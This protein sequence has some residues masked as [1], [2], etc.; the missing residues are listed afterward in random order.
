[1]EGYPVPEAEADIALESYLQSYSEKLLPVYEVEEAMSVLR[2]RIDADLFEKIIR[3]NTDYKTYVTSNRTPLGS[4]IGLRG[5]GSTVS[6]STYPSAAILSELHANA[7]AMPFD[8]RTVFSNQT[9]TLYLFCS[10]FLFVYCSCVSVYCITFLSDDSSFTDILLFAPLYLD[11]TAA[12]WAAAERYLYTP[13]IRTLAGLLRIVED[14][15]D[16]EKLFDNMSFT[17]VVTQLRKDYGSDFNKVLALCRSHI[18][19]EAKNILI[20]KIMGEVAQ[21]PIPTVQQ[22]PS[23]PMGVPLKNEINTRNLKLRLTALARLRQPVYSHVSFVANMVLMKQYTLKPEQRRQRMHETIMAA[24]TTGEPVGHGDRALHIKKF[25]D[26]NIVVRDL[27]IDA[28]RNDR[29]Y[30]IAA[31]ELYLLKNYH[32][33]HTME[34]NMTSGSSLSDDGSTGDMNPWIRFTFKTKQVQGDT[35]FQF[36]LNNI[37]LSTCIVVVHASQQHRSSSVHVCIFITLIPVSHLLS[38]LVLP[39]SF[40]YS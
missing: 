36:T 21:L 38:L 25:V 37:V 28:L 12:V 5:G 30:Q 22:R 6:D 2:G 3:I 8:K 31:M 19:V 39:Y 40:R 23:L 24:L 35:S 32:T 10:N 34:K 17:D 14:Y 33:T 27:L 7:Q 15:L 13:E 11:S 9:G 18:N 29:D 16:V 20:V 4:T 26:G 1:M